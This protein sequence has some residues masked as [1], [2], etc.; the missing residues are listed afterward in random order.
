[1]MVSHYHSIP[2]QRRFIS[3]LSSFF[4]FFSFPF[5]RLHA[6]FPFAPPLFYCLSIFSFSPFLSSSSSVTFLAENVQT[7]NNVLTVSKSETNVKKM[8]IKE[9]R[10]LLP[11]TVQEYR[12]AQLYMIQVSPFFDLFGV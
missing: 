8:L 6:L 2:I 11:M 5:S 1:M 9:Y 4:S 3:F 7:T 12:I 10:I